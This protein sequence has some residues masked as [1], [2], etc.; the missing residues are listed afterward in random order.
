MRILLYEYLTG[1]GLWTE[2]DADL[3][4]HPLLP[5]GRAMVEAAGEDLRR[6]PEVQLVEFRDARLP[7]I[8]GLVRRSRGHHQP[9][10]RVSPVGHLVAIASM[11]CC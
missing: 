8:S 2:T 1:G 6:L 4:Q 5:E 9:G 3:L 10:G 7:P 11:A